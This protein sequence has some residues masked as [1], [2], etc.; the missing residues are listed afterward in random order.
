MRSLDPLTKKTINWNSSPDGPLHTV[1]VSICKNDMSLCRW[2]WGSEAPRQTA[3]LGNTFA[4]QIFNTSGAYTVTNGTG[5]YASY[6]PTAGS[7][8]PDRVYVTDAAG[9]VMQF[10]NVVKNSNN[11]LTLGTLVSVSGTAITNGATVTVRTLTGMYIA[12]K[13]WQA[14]SPGIWKYYGNGTFVKAMDGRASPYPTFDSVIFGGMHI[15][16]SLH[17]PSGGPIEL[18][19]TYAQSGP[20]GFDLYTAAAADINLT[21]VGGVPGTFPTDQINGKLVTTAYMP[22]AVVCANG[23]RV[24]AGAFGTSDGQQVAVFVKNAFTPSAWTLV[25]IL[26]STTVQYQVHDIAVS[27]NTV[28]IVFGGLYAS[29]RLGIAYSTDGGATW[30]YLTPNGVGG[31]TSNLVPANAGGPPKNGGGTLDTTFL[32]NGWWLLNDAT[33]WFTPG[34]VQFDGSGNIW[35]STIRMQGTGSPSIYAVTGTSSHFVFK[36]VIAGGSESFS[37]YGPFLAGSFGFFAYMDMEWLN[38]TV[39][40]GVRPIAVEADAV[41]YDYPYGAPTVGIYTFD[42]ANPAAGWT[43]SKTIALDGTGCPYKY[44]K[45]LP[46]KRNWHETG[47]GPNQVCIGCRWI[48]GAHGRLALNMSDLRIPDVP[49]FQHFSRLKLV[50]VDTL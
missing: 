2:N 23:N 32:A 3:V 48:E 15:G 50:D 1:P 41:L 37:S 36:A 42:T 19:V 33:Y 34:S 43:L 8:S 13:T 47:Y 35:I 18:L 31:F 29:E 27:G 22:K 46:G 5:D 45:K 20:G 9:N 16:M 21:W 28:V 44:S 40:R 49:M 10:G 24:I 30:K 6:T 39:L 11:Q 12:A 26:Y 17:A 14:A 38:T 4:A 25:P 7:P